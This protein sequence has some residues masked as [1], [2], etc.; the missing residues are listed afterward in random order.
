[1]KIEQLHKLFLES[2][3]VCT[4][5]R[6]IKKGCIFFAL[7]GENFDG[8]VFV[9]EALDKGAYRAVIDDM[10]YHRNTGETIL[11]GNALELL[12][13]LATFHRR[14]LGIPIIALTGSNGKTTTKELIDLVLSKR[15]ST[16][17]T[18]GNLNNHIG[19]PLTI[20]SM[21]QKTEIGIVEMGANHQKEI[22]FLSNIA[23]PDYGLITNFGKA[24]LEGFGGV[25]GV[26]KGKS[27]LYTHLRKHGKTVFV[28]GNDPKQME[29]T[30]NMDRFVF[31]PQDSDCPIGQIDQNKETIGVRFR[32][33]TTQTNLIGDYNFSNLAV[34]AA[35]GAYFN[36]DDKMILSALASYIPQNNRSQVVQNGELEVVMDAYNANPTSMMAALKTFVKRSKTPKYVVLGDMFEL[37]KDAQLE[38][39]AIVDFVSRHKQWQVFLIGEN[40]FTSKVEAGHVKIFRDFNYFKSH[41]A[42]LG[43][44]RGSILLKGS[45]GMAIE[46]V[47]DLL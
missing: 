36:V 12:Q 7:K 37:G 18:S 34:A 26:I 10:R 32:G 17:S 6:K 24:H 40:F 5:T 29:L 27:E 41:W 47:L 4:D 21:D 35:I 46:R 25:E 16:T 2:T 15:F 19:V 23:E 11:H 14:Q 42:K 20:L 9:D 43:I 31:G 44:D 38:H 13:K 3:G 39:Q 30:Q 28:N 33:S 8:N 45:R 1:M 22:E